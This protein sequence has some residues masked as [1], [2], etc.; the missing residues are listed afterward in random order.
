MPADMDQ[1]ANSEDDHDQPESSD[2][3]LDIRTVTS[4]GVIVERDTIH[5]KDINVGDEMDIF[6][7]TKRW[8]EGLVSQYH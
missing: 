3:P 5:F 2:F 1:I 6:D 8:C 7:S 4:S